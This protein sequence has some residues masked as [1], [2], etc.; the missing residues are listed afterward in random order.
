M[1]KF[2]KPFFF[3][4]I[5]ALGALFLELI[6]YLIFPEQE[7]QIN[8]Y[9]KITL[10][11]FLVVAIEEAFKVLLV[12]KNSEDFSNE[13]D[14]FISSFFIGAGFALAELFLKD[15]GSK[16][17]SIGNL[18]IF[19]LHILTAGLAGY[20]LSKQRSPRKSYLAKIWFLVFLVHLSY[21]LL[22]IY[23]F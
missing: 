1:K 4:I 16:L 14:I 7:T 10:F 11:L 12:Y 2:I 19:L 23:I 5:A 17:F 13:N 21:N 6:L 15:L 3:G 20:L 22:A 8:Y 9:N 18:N